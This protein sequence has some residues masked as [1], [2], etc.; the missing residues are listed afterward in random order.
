MRSNLGSLNKLGEATLLENMQAQY[1]GMISVLGEW[2]QLRR[3]LID[4]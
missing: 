2:S 3:S 1:G 4:L